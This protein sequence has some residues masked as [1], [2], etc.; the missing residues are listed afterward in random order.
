MKQCLRQIN[1]ILK[2]YNCQIASLHYIWS[3]LK[4][5]CCSTDAGQFAKQ[6]NKP[7]E[8]FS[9]LHDTARSI[10]SRLESS[11]G[12]LFWKPKLD[13][14]HTSRLSPGTSDGRW[15]EPLSLALI[16]PF[17]ASLPAL[18]RC[19][20]T[21]QLGLDL[22]PNGPSTGE[23][24]WALLYCENKGSCIYSPWITSQKTQLVRCITGL[25]ISLCC[26]PRWVTLM[27]SVQWSLLCYLSWNRKFH[28]TNAYLPN[29]FSQKKS[30][31]FSYRTEW[32]HRQHTKFFHPVKILECFTW[33]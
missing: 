1:N 32:A 4:C 13:D 17:S 24:P 18:C 29:R 20:I 21:V 12:H 33:F 3:S 2:I 7:W 8:N 5:N 15:W 25:Q 9:Q 14:S 30:C 31:H 27:C 19:S 26:Y 11:T 10:G 22:L 28:I 23:L 16:P 6:A